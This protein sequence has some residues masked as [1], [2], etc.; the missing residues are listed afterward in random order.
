MDTVGTASLDMAGM[1]GT[2][3]ST[4]DVLFSALSAQ[5]TLDCRWLSRNSL[6]DQ[7]QW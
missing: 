3:V 2:V 6:L 7:L 1:V 4:P 5:M